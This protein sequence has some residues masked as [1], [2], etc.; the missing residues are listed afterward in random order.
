MKPGEEL[1]W[2]GV[3]LLPCLGQGEHYFRV[4]AAPSGESDGGGGTQAATR[5]VHGEQLSGLLLAFGGR[6]LAESEK[7]FV[8]MNE[9][10]KAV[11]EQGGC[12]G[13]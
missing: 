13:S 3:V 5:F 7:A 2:R 12:G 4:E 10:L 8:T 11:A 6:R 9:A 1:R